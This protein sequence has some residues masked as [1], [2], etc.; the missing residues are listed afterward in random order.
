MQVEDFE[1]N[2]VEVI[3]ARHWGFRTQPVLSFLSAARDRKAGVAILVNPYGAFKGVCPIF[4]SA[5]T[6]HFMAVDGIMQGGGTSG[7]D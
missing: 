5:W 3:H 7:R 4:K 1:T 6:S 2:N